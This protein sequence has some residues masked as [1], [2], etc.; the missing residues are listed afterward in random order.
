MNTSSA[1]NGQLL[2]VKILKK[3]LFKILYLVL[4]ELKLDFVNCK[5]FS[6][7]TGALFSTTNKINLVGNFENPFKFS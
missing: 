1:L 6:V 7:T 5:T 4:S 2:A 3:K